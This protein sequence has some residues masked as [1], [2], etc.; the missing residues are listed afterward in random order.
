ML[1][2][3]QFRRNKLTNPGF[4]ADLMLRKEARG[5]PSSVPQ[6]LPRPD[7]AIYKSADHAGNRTIHSVA[8]NCRSLMASSF[9]KRKGEKV[10]FYIL[11]LKTASSIDN[12]PS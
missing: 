2:I 3:S 11:S 5:E 1:N 9:V 6:I 10:Q 12:S 7:P 4:G 8:R